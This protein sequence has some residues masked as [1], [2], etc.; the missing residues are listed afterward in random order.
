MHL[1]PS[2]HIQKIAVDL[3]EVT[4]FS[5]P[6]VWLVT[7]GDMLLM[8]NSQRSGNTF[9]AFRLDLSTK[10][11]KWVKVEKLEKCAIFLSTDDRSQALCC[12]DPERWG[13]RSN[14]IYFYAGSKEWMTC[15]LG[16]PLQRIPRFMRF[17]RDKMMQPMWV[18]P[19]MF[20]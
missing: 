2:I 13:G 1:V 20:Y 11:V 6:L 17:S 10:P 12:M 4:M 18:V 5:S 16:K 19:S 9:E 3:A 7:C 8:V 14:C 15:Q